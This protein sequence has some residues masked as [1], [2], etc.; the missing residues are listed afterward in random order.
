MIAATSLA[1]FWRDFRRNRIAVAA[2]GVVLAVLVLAVAAP[3]F[4]FQDP[5][6][7]AKLNLLD[8][9]RPPGHVSANGEI[10]HLGT[11]AQ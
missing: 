5:Y 4:A 11:D 2:L 9:R 6:D 3:L 8:A 1:A 10:Y 7:I